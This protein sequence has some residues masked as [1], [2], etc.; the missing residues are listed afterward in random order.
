MF[1]LR[2]PRYSG[3]VA[4]KNKEKGEADTNRKASCCSNKR[5][6]PL[7]KVFRCVYH[8]VKSVRIRSYSGLCFSAFGLNTDQNNS[9]Y[10]HFQRRAY[11]IYLFKLYDIPIIM[12]LR[13]NIANFS[14]I[15]ECWVIL[16]VAYTC[17][18]RT[19]RSWKDV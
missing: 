19:L 13:I 12:L 1:L 6:K 5:N 7:Q 15:S 14:E 18:E 10:G 16:C 11:C 3:K 9:E 2:I 17:S 8:C 4:A